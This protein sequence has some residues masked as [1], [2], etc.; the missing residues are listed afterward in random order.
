MMDMRKPI[1][2]IMCMALM[3]GM[4]QCKKNVETIT[5]SSGGTVT[6]S[7]KIGG[8][9]ED[10]EKIIVTPGA[11]TAT[12]SFEAGDVLHVASNGSYLGTISYQGGNTFNGTISTPTVGEPLKLFFLAG[13]TPSLTAGMS[14]SCSIDITDQTGSKYLVLSV[15][16][17]NENYTNRDATYTAKLRNAC[18]F[19]KFNTNVKSSYITVSG[20]YT[21]ASVNFSGTISP[22]GTKG[23]VF[24]KTDGNGVGYAVLFPQT[25]FTA[26]VNASGFTEGYSYIPTITANQYYSTGIDAALKPIGAL[27]GR[28]T[29]NSKGDQVYFSQGNLQYIGSDG[30]WQF[31]EHQYDCLGNT[32][33]QG[34]G[35][36]TVIRDLFG[37]GTTGYRDTRTYSSGY[38]T[39]YYPYSTSDIAVD[40]SSPAYN[41]NRYGYGPDYDDIN[42]YGLTVMNNS[43][44]GVNPIVN[45]G[46]KAELWRTLTIDEWNYLFNTRMTSTGERYVKAKVNDICGVILLP[47]EWGSYYSLSSTDVPNTDFTS[48]IIDEYEWHNI[49]EFNGAVFLPA[50]GTRVGTSVNYFDDPFG[51]YW[52]STS[53]SG[54]Y[55]YVVDFYSNSLNSYHHNVHCDGCSVRLVC[56]V[57]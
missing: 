50:A 49:F 48:N 56:D 15:A 14:T 19:V 36:S 57:E 32:T 5:P 21:T 11:M 12:V 45:G 46:N 20:L 44:W 23:D 43:D 28:F 47:D 51:V 4:M 22:T 9:K 41:I 35:S 10:G 54:M 7:V 34:S 29:I 52:S 37:W 55:V 40:I 38:Q 3:I 31:A 53:Y 42:M 1:V 8:S 25:S 18:A 6:L 39:N 27:W 24:I 30:T 26:R 33:G 2:L 13:K 17:T 16:S